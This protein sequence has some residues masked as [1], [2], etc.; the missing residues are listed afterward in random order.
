VLGADVHLYEP[1]PAYRFQTVSSGRAEPNGLNGGRNPQYG[2]NIDYVINAPLDGPV[3]IEILDGAGDVIQTL[4]DVPRSLGINRAYW[5]LRHE[6]PRLARL[7]VAPPG[8]P[9]VTL[10]DGWRPLRT[11]DLDLN[12]GQRGPLAVPGEYTVRLFVGDREFTQPLTVLKDPHS[13]G[14]IDDIRTQVA[15]TL[16]MRDEL[17]QIVDM[18]DDIEWLRKQLED[19]QSKYA[20]DTSA[21]AI[22][23]A[24]RELEQRAMDVEGNLFD[25][26]LTGARE[27]AFRTPMRLYGRLSALASDLN[28][29]GADFPP[30]VQQVE[31]HTQFKQQ[32]AEYTT[33]YLELMNE[34]TAAFRRLLQELGI[35]DI[36]SAVLPR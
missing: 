33:L 14:T 9:F 20:G 16:E 8:K 17:N 13:T 26:H 30:T 31:V 19:L 6:D 11:W 24:A 25:I 2:E 12:G 29:N 1:R 10:E 15:R 27:D 4:G 22:S 36:I 3:R 34:D 23:D 21:T 28:A 35:P 7:R 5:N 18:I 32:L